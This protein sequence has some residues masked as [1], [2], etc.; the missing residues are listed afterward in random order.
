MNAS[1]PAPAS[2]C[3]SPRSAIAPAFT[4]WVVGAG[5]AIASLGA[6]PLAAANEGFAGIWQLDNE[7]S[8]SLA[9]G[10]AGRELPNTADL[11]VDISL[12]G[13][14]VV[15]H[16][17]MRRDDQQAPIQFTQELTTDGKPVVIPGIQGGTR[18]ARVKWRKDKL[19]ISYT[20][21]TPFGDFDITETWQLSKDGSELQVT[22]HTRS[23]NPR[24]DIR[25]LIY[26]RA[27][28]VQ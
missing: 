1:I 2:S 9:P 8:D 14:D 28:A 21:S 10:R 5:L 26:V 6:A 18:T 16:F 12:A 23:Q 25:K 15:M 3:H 13:E 17:T 4:A 22:L 11:E 20:R 27:T 19:S 7:R 24:P